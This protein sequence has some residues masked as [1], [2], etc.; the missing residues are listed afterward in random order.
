MTAKP[1]SKA[2]I[3][4][5]RR[6]DNTKSRLFIA[7][8]VQFYLRITLLQTKAFDGDVDLVVITGA[9]A[10]SAIEGKL[11]DRQ[12]KERFGDIA[13]VIGA[14]GQR[15]CNVLSIAAATGLP[16]E[17]VRRKIG[18]LVARG[19]VMRR[20]VSDYILQPGAIQS[21]AFAL[22]FTDIINETIRFM[23]D[24]LSEE[25]LEAVE[26]PASPDRPPARSGP[27]GTD[28]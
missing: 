17:T 26:Q 8:F 21:P 27:A 3:R 4:V 9:I 24:C 14:D 18:H 19:I 13:T 23:N 5:V 12:F 22:M 15:G 7:A 2:R 10:L 1:S 28:A 25:V 6:P 20:G 11:R 16:R